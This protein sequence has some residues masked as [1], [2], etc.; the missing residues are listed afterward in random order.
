MPPIGYADDDEDIGLGVD[1]PEEFETNADDL[2]PYRGDEG[3]GDNQG[4]QQ[5]KR[6]NDPEGRGQQ[7]Q[8]NQQQNK[9]LRR[10][11]REHFGRPATKE[12]HDKLSRYLHDGQLS[13]GE[14]GRYLAAK[15]EIMEALEDLFPQS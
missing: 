15:E 3:G 8:N 5:N 10:Y 11:E 13:D 4:Q 14:E 9:D 7:S 1:Q 12:E 6:T 2:C